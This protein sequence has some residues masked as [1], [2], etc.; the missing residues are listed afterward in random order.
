MDMYGFKP[1]EAVFY[2]GLLLSFVALVFVAVVFVLRYLKSILSERALWLAGF[3]I[4]LAGVF[5]M[6]PW[7][8][9]TMLDEQAKRE[10]EEVSVLNTVIDDGQNTTYKI[11][12]KEFH[13][14]EYTPF[15]H[16]AQYLI[17]FILN[18]GV[19]YGFAFIMASTIY[20]KVLG[21][22]NQV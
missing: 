10:K 4:T 8:T 15:I 20:S 13:W 11:C 5:I 9:N 22:L 18:M 6:M 3:V 19:G 2:Q 16:L 17:G 21:N 7:G 1:D 12:Y 14:C